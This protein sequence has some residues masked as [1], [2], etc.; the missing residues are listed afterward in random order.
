[1]HPDNPLTA[2]VFVNR[3]WGHLFGE[4]LVRTPSDFGLRCDLP[5]QQKLLD[6]LATEF[7]AG[8]WSLKQL[9][10]ELVTTSTYRQS[11]TPS[12]ELLAADPENELWGRAN[13][14]RLDFESLRDR[15]LDVADQ[16]DTQ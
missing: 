1:M 4:H 6:Y 7:T 3:V 11:S 16:L 5:R 8:G 12:R 2:R 13:R 14:R 10:R 15:L 9:V